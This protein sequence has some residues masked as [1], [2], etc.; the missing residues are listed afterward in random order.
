MSSH[1]PIV[2]ERP[3][4]WSKENTESNVELRIPSKLERSLKVREEKLV[5]QVKY[6][7]QG[8]IAGGR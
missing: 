5:M 8:L 1:A 6:N 2:T 4:S 3:M 7:R